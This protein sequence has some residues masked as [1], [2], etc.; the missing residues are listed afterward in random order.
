MISKLLG[1][2]LYWSF[3]QQISYKKSYNLWKTCIQKLHIYTTNNLFI[4]FVSKS[5]QKNQ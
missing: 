3:R 4:F 1:I 2:I 5:A